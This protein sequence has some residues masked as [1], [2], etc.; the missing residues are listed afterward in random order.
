MRKNNIKCVIL[1]LL[2]LFVL[3]SSIYFFMPRKIIESSTL[4]GPLM[5][6]FV[7]SE[8]SDNKPVNKTYRYEINESSAKFHKVTDTLS[9]YRYHLSM[10]TLTKNTLSANIRYS[11]I[12]SAANNTISFCDDSKIIINGSVYKIGYWGNR[13]AKKLCNELINILQDN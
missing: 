10:S 7:K 6:S 1:S 8:F 11:F 13:K 2:L 4:K 9:K 5:I 3:C 12:I